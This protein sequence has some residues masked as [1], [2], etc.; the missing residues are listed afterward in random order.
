VGVQ[1]FRTFSVDTRIQNAIE[2]VQLWTKNPILGVGYNRIRYEKA[3]LGL[4]GKYD[5]SHAASSYHSSFVTML[6]AGGALGLLGL[7]GMLGMLG[8]ISIP[9]FY[10]ILFLSILSCGD[11]ALLHPFILFLLLK[12]LAFEFNQSSLE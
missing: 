2:G 10:Y 3:G 11:N 5:V 4:T 12:L 9:S 7:L 8:R 1:L 6:V